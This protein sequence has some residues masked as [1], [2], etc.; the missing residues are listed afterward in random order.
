[1]TLSVSITGNAGSFLQRLHA[2]LVN[3]AGFNARIA[4]NAEVFLR[5]FIRKTVATR[6]ATARRLGAAQTG[7]LERAVNAITSKSNA[8]AATLQIANAGFAR[9]VRDVTI[10]PTHGARAL[11]IPMNAE[12]YGARA[13]E[14]E[15]RGHPL[16]IIRT[17]GKA[18]LVRREEGSKKLVFLYAL[19]KSVFQKK[20]PSLLPTTAEFGEVAELT[21][22]Q[23]IKSL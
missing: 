22:R 16:F 15:A 3:P 17:K 19:V 9:A 5:E 1:M 21:A 23:F 13:G 6:H 2:E 4:T 8:S 12:S 14:F 10:T 7:F 18:Y 20:D 11:T